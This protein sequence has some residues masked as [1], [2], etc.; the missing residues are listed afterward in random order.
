MP[1]QLSWKKFRLLTFEILGHLFKIL[2]AD[3]DYPVLNRDNLTIPIQMNLSKKKKS[4]S[5]FLTAFTKS[6][7]NFKYFEQKDD[8]HRFCT[9]DITDSEN[10]VR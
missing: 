6:R 4:F 7:L 8:R 5:E 1:S 2:A 9:S 10:V 3:D